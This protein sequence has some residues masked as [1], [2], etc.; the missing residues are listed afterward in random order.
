M[1][2]MN[3]MS[4][5][6]EKKKRQNQSN[7]EATENGAAK[8][9]TKKTLKTVLYSVIAV[10]VVAAIVFLG[11][12]STGFF[13]KHGTAAVVNGHK[14]SPAMVNFFYQGAYQQNSEFLSYFTDSSTPLS[15]QEFGGE[16]YDTWA[17]YLMDIALNSAAQMYAIY[18]EAVAN[19]FTLSEDEQASIDS[20]LQMMELYASVYGFNNADA[21]LSYYYGTGCTTK[22]YKEYA[23]VNA[24]AQAYASSVDAGL[25]Y[26]Q[27]DIDSYYNE[28]TEDFDGVT[29]RVFNINVDAEAEDAEAAMAACEETAKTMAEASQGSEDAFLEYALLN[30]AEESQETYDADSATLRQDYSK[31]SAGTAY[32]DWLFDSSRQSG[33]ATY[34]ENGDSGYS[35]VYF[36]ENADHSYLL[37]NVRHI[38]VYIS[39]TTD[40]EAMATAQEEA[41]AI[42]DEFLAGDQTEEAF[43][44]LA[45]ENSYDSS[46]GGLIENVTRADYVQ[47][48]VDWSYDE[49]RQVGDTGIIESEYGY[50]VMLFCGYGQTY[51]DYTVENTM[52][53]NDYSA[54]YSDVTADAAYTTNAFFMR[55][56][57]K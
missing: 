38:L 6:R 15:E 56:T 30:T 22:N 43:A 46:E 29:Y 41:Q 47:S 36:V 49:S 35:V 2:G 3:R 9:Q 28:H 53:D 8:K 57:N 18:D 16:T 54:W 1:R 14:L 19:G 39:D 27:E 24:L 42:L 13:A 52:R 17:D 25:T 11:M 23:T 32:A 40:E 50:H 34:V 12:V 48:F 55:F 37:P 7:V 4:A 10:V 45:D 51:Q 33:D 26:T 20:E 31:A 44:A 21:Y 5:S